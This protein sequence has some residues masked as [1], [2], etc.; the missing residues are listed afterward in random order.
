M[1][2]RRRDATGSSFVP[3]ARYRLRVVSVRQVSDGAFPWQPGS[4]R[5]LCCASPAHNHLCVACHSSGLLRLERLLSHLKERCR[6]G[7]FY[8]VFAAGTAV[9]ATFPYLVDRLVAPRIGG[10]LATLVFP[11]AWTS[12]EYL[13]ALIG[14]FGTI[15]SIA[16]TQYGNL[17]LLQ[18]VSVTG[19][20]GLS[21]VITWL[22]PIVNW[23]W[24]QGFTW[25][26]IRGG[27]LL[28]SGI[29]T[30]ILLG[31]GAR[32]AFITPE[33][34]TVRV[35]GISPSRTVEANYDQQRRS[36]AFDALFQGK[37]TDNQRAVARTAY[38]QLTNDLFVRTEQEA[39]AGAKIVLWP[40]AGTSVLQEDEAAFLTR[41]STLTRNNGI[42]LEMGLIIVTRQAPFAENKAL[43]IA[44][45]GEVVW[46]YD[47]A[48]P[49][50]GEPWLP[51][52]AG[53][54]TS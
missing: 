4:L 41:G 51:G 52:M 40:E 6:P 54:Q 12:Y 9:A 17:P 46:S 8:F 28:Y 44:P 15:G 39:K 42:Y 37:A 22:A 38:A 50:P 36:G 32:L 35:V 33:A 13:T 3:L 11:L 5:C 27:I 18:L 1:Y 29:L 43:L 21:F 7:L 31:G 48:H 30:V 25:S 53:Y 34:N 20:W 45:T 14:P 24:E 23:A 49:V 19:I 16:Y 26:R 47:K 10:F 2:R